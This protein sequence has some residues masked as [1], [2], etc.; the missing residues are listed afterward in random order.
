MRIFLFCLCLFFALPSFAQESS[1]LHINK[2][3]YATG[4]VVWFNYFLPDRFAEQTAIVEVI[5]SDR[6]G[7]AV[8]RFY[9]RNEESATIN[10][11]YKIPF[12]L[13]SDWYRL[14]VLSTGTQSNT[15]AD[16][17]FPIY[18]DLAP[19]PD[20]ADQTTD[21]AVNDLSAGTM[22]VSISLE[23]DSYAPRDLVRGSIQ[24]RDQ[25]GNPVATTLSLSVQDAQL[26]KNTLFDIGKVPT[27][28]ADK[29]LVEGTL[30]DNDGQPMR[31]GVLGMYAGL[32]NRIYYTSA[33]EKGRFAFDPPLF[34]DN[35][36]VQFIGYQFEHTEITIDLDERKMPP[37]SAQLSY[38]KSVRDYLALSRQRKKV[39]QIYNSLETQLVPEK[40]KIDVQDLETDLSYI[41]S[42]YESFEFM[43]DFFGELITP[44]KFI[45]QKDSTYIAELYNPTGRTSSNTKLSGTPL[46]IVDGKLTRDADFV[47]RMDMDYVE[48]VELM[49]RTD[50]LRKKFSA[51]GRSGV[52]KITTNLKDVPVPKGET[53]D[54]F[55]LPG[56]QRPAP[57]PTFDANAQQPIFLPQLYWNPT[58]TTDA[59]GKAEFSF[60]QSDD[61][62]QFVIHAIGQSENG[63]YGQGEIQYGVK[64]GN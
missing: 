9:L 34:Y 26:A 37:I 58:I 46:F 39:F 31:A 35:Y 40:V 8:D 45:Y 62:S 52:I 24:V 38:P 22:S 4:E 44:L 57:F 10:G 20:N 18:N 55:T 61:I 29:V 13:D 59:N 64:V 19:L 2:S 15:L 21:L 11:Y 12:T 27:T 28:L 48:K 3:F 53:D 56:L 47:A 43:H 30:L 41:I 49:Y 63:E 16:V 25:N 42:E 6:A 51:I 5:I 7:D 33:N 36:P 17:V 1:L 23:K 60:Y 50:N 54:V 32:E 14:S